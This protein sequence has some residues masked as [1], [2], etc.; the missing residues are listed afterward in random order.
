MTRTLR[1]ALTGLA[2][3]LACSSVFAQAT[4]QDISR[5]S[6]LHKKGVRA[7]QTGEL[8]RA[9]E[10]FNESLKILPSYPDAHIGLGQIAMGQG[11]FEEALNHFNAAKEGYRELGESLVDVQARRYADAQRQINQLQDSIRQIQSQGAG[12]GMLQVNINTMENQIQQLQAIEPPNREAA[13]EPPGEVYFYIGN[14]LFQLNRRPEALEAWE[15]CRDKSPK[16]AMV[17]NNLALVYMMSGRLEAAK[18]S[19]AKA[20]EL[21]FPV[22]PQFK[23]DLDKA[24]AESRESGAG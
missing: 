24:I 9:R 22:N 4:S 15:T 3:L 2:L 8:E 16:F 18:E 13:S 6:K 20:E 1:I 17:H 11:S 21:G 5:A 14:A 23:Q 10:S 7:L 19:L 12:G